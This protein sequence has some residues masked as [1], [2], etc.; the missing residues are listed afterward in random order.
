MGRER[1]GEGRRKMRGVDGVG[2]KRK[3]DG[4]EGEGMREEMRGGRA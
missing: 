1:G 2:V 4:R 3:E